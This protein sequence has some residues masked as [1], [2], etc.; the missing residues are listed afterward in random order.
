MIRKTRA[1][2]IMA[3]VPGEP[4]E[5]GGRRWGDREGV[6]SRASSDEHLTHEEVTSGEMTS[7]TRR[8][9]R[10]KGGGGTGN[11][12]RR[13]SS[14]ET[15]GLFSSRR[16]AATPGSLD[17]TVP[18]SV[19]ELL[20]RTNERLR[21]LGRCVT[22]TLA[23]DDLATTCVAL[24]MP[25]LWQLRYEP[26]DGKKRKEFREMSNTSEL[27][28]ESTN[29]TKIEEA[30]E[31][32]SI[33]DDDYKRLKQENENLRQELHN[34]RRKLE[35]NEAFQKDLVE[36]Y[37]NADIKFKK[38]AERVEHERESR[39]EMFRIEK[40]KYK[41]HI[42]ALESNLIKSEMDI[43]KLQEEQKKYEDLVN[44]RLSCQTALEDSLAQYKAEQIKYFS[45][46][47]DN[48]EKINQK[49]EIEKELKNQISIL[50]AHIDELDTAWKSTKLQ[51]VKKTEEY[52][53]AQETIRE[54]AANLMELESPDIVPASETRKGNSLFAEVEDR[55]Q[56]LMDKIKVITN[57][58]NEVKRALNTKTA[59][60]STLRAEKFKVTKQWEADMYDTLQE[61]E[62]LLNKYKSRVF[63]LEKK[64]KAEM[65]KNEQMEETQFTE[66]SFNYAETLLTTKR[67]ELKELKEENEKQARKL[68]EQNEANQH[69]SAQLRMW[70]AKA[71]SLETEILQ[72][73]AKLENIQQINDNKNLLDTMEDCNLHDN[74]SIK[75]TN[76]DSKPTSDENNIV[77]MNNVCQ[78][79]SIEVPKKR[80]VNFTNEQKE[81]PRKCVDFTKDTKVQSKS[82]KSPSDLRERQK[83][84]E[85]PII[86]FE[87]D[88]K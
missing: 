25:Q 24:M 78:G 80:V 20:L 67:K 52:E 10:T 6:P 75:E 53:E 11:S 37:E 28:C 9:D 79:N 74:T 65:K 70:R 3:N 48:T 69:I 38:H 32:N 29:D 46:L 86:S 82:V 7:A 73:K 50:E 34:L 49:E 56:V 14:R 85:Y 26:P 21:Y 59:E 84:V 19:R 42:E 13:G 71:A 31:K 17:L 45:V 77:T 8:R 54:L 36:S 64:L 23:G 61:N 47:E 87:D 51:L 35:T 81:L 43:K 57:K 55:R 18:V 40:R 39:E 1:V 63:D 44:K 76:D 15:H 41:D 16:V 58:Y 5:R 27:N 66:N 4:R 30:L 62:D 22:L 60:L 33:M 2:W 12:A 72:L 88:T 68:L 83:R